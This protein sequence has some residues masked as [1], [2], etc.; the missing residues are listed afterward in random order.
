MQDRYIPGRHLELIN[1]YLI[2][3]LDDN[4][5]L[6]RLC[7][8]LP[9]RHGKSTLISTYTPAYAMMKFKHM[10]IMQISYGKSLVEDFTL[11]SRDIVDS[12]GPYSLDP[13]LQRKD[14]YQLER[15][16]TSK[17]FCSGV[18]GP[19]TGKGA[20]LLILDDLVNGVDDALNE[21]HLTKLRNWYEG[22]LLSRLH[23]NGRILMV[24]TR[25]AVDDIIGQILEE[26]GWTIIDLPVYCD[27]PENDLLGREEGEILWPEHLDEEFIA[28][29][30][31]RMGEYWF[32]VS[33]MGRPYPMTGNMIDPAYIQSFSRVHVTRDH[34]TRILYLDPAFTDGALNPQADYS[35]FTVVDFYGGNFYVHKQVAGQWA[36][37]K[38][39]HMASVLFNT[40]KPD[41]FKIEEVSASK[42]MIND[43][44]ELGIPVM[45]FNP[46]QKSKESRLM[47]LVPWIES[48]KVF[49]KY[50]EDFTECL[51]QLRS[52][53]HSRKD[54]FI[55]SLWGALH[56][57]STGIC[58]YVK[59]NPTRS[60]TY[61]FSNQGLKLKDERSQSIF[62][63]TMFE[64]LMNPYSS[65]KAKI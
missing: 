21:K 65:R 8:V 59:W 50:Q 48:G 29:K 38:T 22:T 14:S 58:P 17:C 4:D 35:V 39:K 27:D 61:D 24:S 46:G 1:E 5:P 7:V 52:F 60:N 51:E 55:D 43:L 2:K 25:W 26:D 32:T 44:Q 30:R 56:N 34:R 54:D 11:A 19:I 62:V 42:I 33:Y 10:Q 40:W 37:P 3:L 15:P 12:Y 13:S 63:G 31:K 16:N 9:P 36:T 18:M 64:D 57:V 41:I 53:P 45:G 49:F 20:D 47:E 28:D 23:K 6:D